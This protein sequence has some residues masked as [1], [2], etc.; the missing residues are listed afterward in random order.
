MTRRFYRL[1]GFFS[2][3][4]AG[5]GSIRRSANPRAQAGVPA[6]REKS[7]GFFAGLEDFA[8]SAKDGA[9][10]ERLGHQSNGRVGIGHFRGGVLAVAGHEDNRDARMLALKLHSEFLASHSRHHHI[11]DEQIDLAAMFSGN[12]DGFLAVF[13]FDHLVAA[14]FQKFAG[15]FTNVLLVLGQKHGFRSGGNFRRRLWRADM[16][17]RLVYTRKI[18]FERRAFAEFAVDPNETAALLDD[19]VY[20]GQSKTR[21]FSFFLGSKERLE[22]VRLGFFVHAGA[23]VG[24]VQQ[25]VRAGFHQRMA[26]R[27]GLI[28]VAIARA[29][30]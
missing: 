8:H 2:S 6:P 24:D 19:A 16:H 14:G 18:N 17:F 13:R 26:G 20:G 4:R 22:D 9:A 11:G 23:G 15:N 28:K 7:S 30:Q 1:G 12:G 29:D 25:N 27:V 5:T 21:A 3:L 10:A